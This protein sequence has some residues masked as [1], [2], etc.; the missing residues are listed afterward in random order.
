MNTGTL[1]VLNVAVDEERVAAFE[2]VADDPPCAFGL[3]RVIAIEGDLN[4]AF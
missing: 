4:I 1:E 3:H 2:H